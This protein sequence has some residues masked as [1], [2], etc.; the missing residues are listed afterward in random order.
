MA[1]VVKSVFKS[2]AQI[3]LSLF[4]KD[5]KDVGDIAMLTLAVL[6][7]DDTWEASEDS[8][9]KKRLTEWTRK[10]GQG[11]RQN[12]G[13]ILW[14]AGESATPLKNAVE[15]LMAWQAI[16]DDANRG[17][18]GE[19][20]S[21]DLRR[22]QFELSQAKSQIEE[23]VW[24]GY[25]HLLLWDGRE[26][27]LRDV[28]LGQ[29]HPSEAKN[30]TSAIL[31]RLRHES[32]LTGEIGASY[33][34]RNWPPALKEAGTWPLAGLK[35]AFFQGHFTRL[36][37]ADDALRQTICRA[38]DQGVL[39]LASGK[40][41]AAFDRVWFK[42]PV[43]SVEVTFDNDT[44]LLRVDRAKELK[45]TGG[46]PVPPTPPP[47]GEKPKPPEPPEPPEQPEPPKPPKP[48]EL[49]VSWEGDL[50]R[51]QWNLFSL[52]VLTKLAN[53]EGL[54]IQVKVRAKL[55]DAHTLEQL[56]DALKELGMDGEFGDD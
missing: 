54:D 3:H 11:N 17:V 16:S 24:S 47:G 37:K 28:T 20:E 31:A 45:E 8:E 7:P 36:E 30:I 44:Y 46:K 13:G 33:I 21:D 53:A 51:E 39:G 40:D 34:E 42:E 4:P 26:G 23:R 38:V 10:C 48:T 32:L 43:E 52:K 19:L 14:I 1:E 5:S 29:L 22:I 56:N 9:F 49:A 12:P 15:E 50:A 35:A 41:T 55:K 18:L 27:V 25:N 2:N 6:R